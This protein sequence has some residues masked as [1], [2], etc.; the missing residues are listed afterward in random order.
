M[1]RW[2]RRLVDSIAHDESVS[3]QVR[4]FRLCCVTAFVMC[5]VVILPVN[6]FQNLPWMV[7]VADVTI[8]LIAGFCYWDSLR[9]RHHIVLFLWAMLVLL[10]PVWFFN[11]GSDGSI[12]YYFFPVLLLPVAVLEGRTRFWMTLVVGLNLAVLLLLEHAFPWWTVPF[13]SPVDRLLDLV[14]GALCASIALVGLARLILG[15]YERDRRQLSTYADRLAASERNYREIFNATSDA[16]LIHDG[17]GRLVDVNQMMCTMYGYDRETALRQTVQSLSV[18]VSPYSQ[19]E[20]EQKIAQTL[21]EGPQVFRWR[22]RRSNGELFWAEVALRAGEVAGE[23]RVIAS[24]RDITERVAAEE[25]VREQ[26]ERL[27]LALEASNQGWFE[28]N[29]VSGD[30]RVSSEYARMVHRDPSD[31]RVTVP[32]WLEWIHPEDRATAAAALADCKADGRSRT[33]EYRRRA[34]D[35]SWRWI[36]IVG[37]IVEFD[38]D[39]KP[40]RMLGT[41]ADITAAKEIEA[42]LRNN[43]RLQ[44]VATLAGGVAHDLN[45]LLT[46]MLV[47]GSLL[48]DKVQEAEDRELLDSLEAGAKRGAAIVRQ[49]LTFS[50]SLAQER[51]KIDVTRF[52]QQTAE[53]MRKVLPTTITIEVKVRPDIWS[54]SADPRLLQQVFDNL[55]ANAQSAMPRGGTLRLAADNTYLARR[56]ATR[57]PWGKDGPVVA[58]TVSDTGDGIPPG[59]IDRIFDPF[60]TTKAVGQ[61]PGLGLSVVYGIVSGLG[62]V[63]SVESPPGQGATFRVQLPATGVEIGRKPA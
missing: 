5:L 31:Q 46:P 2:G 52:L 60:F 57:N 17:A 22:C 36:R 21:T 29:L 3:L 27:R 43:Q 25:A 14:S 37:K 61:G 48:H 35:G 18:G 12:S 50:Q 9:G 53:R 32:E 49:L 1:Q 8:G 34:A 30:G 13:K 56:A 11:A 19:V 55:C 33:V 4:L 26:E 62:G 28:L 10:N 6:S 7:N 39:G 63:V 59:I 41:H 38:R 51:V 15:T 24:V 16:L 44:A 23:R 58:F 40:L 45:N 42:Q 54:V 20:A 47:A